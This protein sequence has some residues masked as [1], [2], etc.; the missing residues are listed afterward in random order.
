MTLSSGRIH[1][2]FDIYMLLSDKSTDCTGICFAQYALRNAKSGRKGVIKNLGSLMTSSDFGTCVWH[3]VYEIP[4]LACFGGLR[5]P[6]EAGAFQ[7]PTS[8]CSLPPHA[9]GLLIYLCFSGAS[10]SL[11]PYRPYWPHR[12]LVSRPP[13]CMQHSL[14]QLVY[15]DHY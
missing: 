6:R 7:R 10:S 9:C 4:T 8:A 12:S 15:R 2:C 14:L 1:I 11:G 3:V 13:C 5:Y